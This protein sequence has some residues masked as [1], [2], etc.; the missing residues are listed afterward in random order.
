MGYR[1]F[2]ANESHDHPLDN[3]DSKTV[4][5][6]ST[7]NG[8]RDK[9]MVIP[10]SS[11]SSTKDWR[12]KRVRFNASGNSELP[13]DSVEAIAYQD[14][15]SEEELRDR[16]FTAMEFATF[17]QN[18]KLIAREC[19][20]TVYVEQF[21]VVYAAAKHGNDLKRVAAERSRVCA[22]PCR[23]LERLIFN[24]LGMEAKTVINSVLRAQAEN[25]SKQSIAACSRGCSKRARNLA[26]ILGHGDAAYVRACRRVEEESH[27]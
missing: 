16:W 26:R 1:Q 7:R 15:L 8:D 3:G 10:S 22:S 21:G 13:V 14:D 19:K 17:K 9:G 25:Q 24:E 4:M 2:A 6:K 12:Q 20:Q 23:G 11:R 5:E 27:R 18:C